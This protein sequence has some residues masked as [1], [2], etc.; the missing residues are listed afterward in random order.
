MENTS[1][2]ALLLWSCF[3]RNIII[4]NNVYIKGNNK[5]AGGISMKELS[6][7]EKARRYDE[8]IERARTEYKKHEAFKGF[9]EMLVNIFPELKMSEDEKIRKQIISFLKEFEYDHYRCLD[10]SSWIDWLEKQGEQK[11]KLYANDNAKEMFIRA[12]ERVEEQNSKGYKLTDCDKNSW[13][14]DFKTYTS[15]QNLANSAK[16][17][18]IEPKFKEGDWV[19][20]EWAN[21]KDLFQIKNVDCF[22]Y[23]F[24]EYFTIPFMYEDVLSKWTINDAKEGDVLRLGDVIAI[25]KKY[26]GQEECICYCSSCVNAGF[27]IPIENGEDN[28]YGCT[29][30]T[31][32]TKEQRDLLFAKMK[33][34]GYEWDAMKKQLKKL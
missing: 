1:N 17:C 13:W 12:L 20:I 22:G 9:C 21:K 8:A 27:E 24:D 23:S 29:N 15:E 16:T 34:A 3:G 28:V 25:F 26:I 32:A 33:D 30:T 11:L 7:E 18:K 19:F 10:F 2:K 6:T 4:N 14:E 5:V 31:P